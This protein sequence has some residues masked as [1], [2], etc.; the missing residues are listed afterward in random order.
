MNLAACTT[1]EHCGTVNSSRVLGLMLCIVEEGLPSMPPP[2]IH[3]DNDTNARG[4]SREVFRIAN[5]QAYS[6]M[7]RDQEDTQKDDSHNAQNQG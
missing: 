3:W 2:H 5:A 4:R 6:R 7:P 1:L